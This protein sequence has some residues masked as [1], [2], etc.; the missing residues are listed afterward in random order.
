MFG[1]VVKEEHDQNILQKLVIPEVFNV[2]VRPVKT[3]LLH[4][5]NILSLELLNPLNVPHLVISRSFNLSPAL[6]NL[7]PV[8]SPSIIIV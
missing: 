1:T 8:I 5:S 3:K 6:A 4:P 2:P 7:N